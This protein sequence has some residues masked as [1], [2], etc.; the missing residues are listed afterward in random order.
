MSHKHKQTPRNRFAY[1]IIRHTTHTSTCEAVQDSKLNLHTR[2][3][4]IVIFN[5]NSLHSPQLHLRQFLHLS[6]YPQLSFIWLLTTFFAKILLSQAIHHHDYL[7]HLFRRLSLK[8]LL[9]RISLSPLYV[10]FEH[11]VAVFQ[12]PSITNHQSTS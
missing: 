1:Q 4:D 6:K 5:L 7:N 3:L 9:Q 8:S 11:L 2:E 10:S 12:D